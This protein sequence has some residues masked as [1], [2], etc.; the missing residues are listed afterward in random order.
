MFAELGDLTQSSDYTLEVNDDSA[1]PY[2]NVVY[3]SA[4]SMREV[5][6]DILD[7]RNTIDG[8]PHGA[9]TDAMLR[10]LSGE[11]NTNGDEKITTRELYRYTKQ[12]VSSRNPHTPQL[13]HSETADLDKS[14]L[15]VASNPGIPSLMQADQ[16]LRVDIQ[17]LEPMH[18]FEP[19]FYLRDQI[20]ALD[21][22]VASEDNSD[23]KVRRDRRCL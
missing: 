16:P 9:L 7:G 18:N 22:V 10:G 11:A 14:V 20:A 2:R 12:W 8:R 3:I 6:L 23:V 15:G 4:S 19:Y 17:A 1:Y 13:L 21:G 5:A